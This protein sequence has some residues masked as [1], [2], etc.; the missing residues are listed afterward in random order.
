MTETTK[1]HKSLF[2]VA[3]TMMLTGIIGIVVVAQTTPQVP[4]N[5]R[6]VSATLG[7]GA[8]VNV[9][10]TVQ[11]VTAVSAALGDAST[12]PTS[13]P[14]SPVS[15]PSAITIITTLPTSNPTTSPT[16]QPAVVVVLPP[17]PV[18]SGALWTP[19]AHL[20]T[21]T[22]GQNGVNTTGGSVNPLVVLNQSYN[23]FTN[24]I[25]VDGGRPGFTLTDCVV[26][27]SFRATPSDTYGGQGVFLGKVTGPSKFVGVIFYNNGCPPG[28]PL[29]EMTQFR[30]HI[31]Q[32]FTDS[33]RLVCDHCIFYGAPNAGCQSRVGIDATDCVF[34]GC[35]NAFLSIMGHSSMTH[36][37]VYNGGLMAVDGPTDA[38]GTI[39]V[40]SWTGGS[41]IAVQGGP[42][43]MADVQII[44]APG[45]GALPAGSPT[46]PIYLQGCINVT[47]TWGGA[48][49][50]HPEWKPDTSGLPMLSATNCGIFGWPGVSFTGYAGAG[51]TVSK[52]TVAYDCSSLIGAAVAGTGSLTP[53]ALEEKIQSDLRSAVGA[54]Q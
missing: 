52:T 53:E 6:S 16:S 31:Y 32:Q 19:V 47:N 21:V 35:G 25:V 43:A 11:V 45:Q 50:T 1:H 20:P 48:G 27:N 13:Q 49:S 38:S 46:V 9:P 37:V 15:Q 4:P 36:C 34:I 3:G 12:Q 54:N 7:S 33:G 24:G 14:V 42:L 29:K 17:Q 5:L 40:T 30:H 26:Q 44:G 51:F 8:V 39:G 2:A 10:L 23:G 41:A 28:K 22:T 18:S